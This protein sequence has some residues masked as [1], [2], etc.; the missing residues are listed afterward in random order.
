MGRTRFL[1]LLFVASACPVADDA[2][3]VSGRIDGKKVHFPAK[4]V[5]GGVKATIG[6]LESCSDHSLVSLDELRKAREGDHVRLVFA[7]PIP[8]TVMEQKFEA[9]EL[10]VRLPLNTGVIWLWSGTKVRR[11]AKFEHETAKLFETWLREAQPAD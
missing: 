11:Y 6:L 8:V 9:S 3:R 1:V 5:A 2:V 4:G 7:K 10:V